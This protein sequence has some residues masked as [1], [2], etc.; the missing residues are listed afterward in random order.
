[1]ACF[2]LIV[3]SFGFYGYWNAAPPDRTCISC[4]EIEQSYNM[5]A[6][7]AHK[8][9]TCIECHGTA[10]SNGIHSL[11]EKAR[12]VFKHF[13]EDTHVNIALNEEQVIAMNQTCRKCHHAEYAAWKSGGHSVNFSHIFLNEE[14]NSKEQLN[15]DCLR[16]HGM[17]YEKDIYSL[18]EPVSIEGPWR[19]NDPEKSIQPVIPCLTCHLIHEPGIPKMSFDYR[20]SDSVH[21]DRLSGN[22]SIFFNRLHGYS[23]A[24][25]YDRNERMFLNAYHL[26]KPVMWESNRQVKVSDDPLMRLCVQCHAPNAWHHAGSS[27]DRTPTGVHEGISCLACHNTHSNL[28][29][30]SC[31]NCHPAISNCN[32][33]VMA[34][35]TSFAFKDSPNNIHFVSCGDCHDGKRP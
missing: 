24:G 29:V 25:L 13:S 12:M 23:K 22:D 7:S 14:Q 4:H 30:N 31:M 5:W 10:L 17:F 11:K 33:D 16:C 32:L 2:I 15:H 6:I 26:P 3:G 8:D 1:M 21:Y 19:L 27:D 28:A 34:M 20:G 35:N 18:V 9:V